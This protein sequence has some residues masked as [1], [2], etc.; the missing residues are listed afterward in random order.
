MTH[1]NIMFFTNKGRVFQL[2]AYRIPVA[3]R[4]SKGKPIVNLLPRLEDGEK[5]EDNLPIDS[6]DESLDLMFATRGG[7]VKRTP[8]RE[9]RNIRSNGIIAISLQDGDS[10]VDTRMVRQ[11]DEIVLATRNGQ[12]AR[13]EAS[14]VRSVGRPSIGVIGMRPDEGDEVV[15]MAVVRPEDKLLSITENGYGKIS[16][17]SDYRKTHRGGKGVITIK[18]TDRNGMVVSV[19]TINDDDQIILTTV[20]GNV[21][22]TRAE[23]IRTM[24]RSTQGVTIMG[25]TNGDKITAVARLVGAKEEMMVVHTE[26]KEGDDIIPVAGDPENEEQ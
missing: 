6:L 4:H 15:S 21:I 22:R 20:Q 17:V 12:A 19:S 26:A 8:L 16:L 18:T 7:I 13:F 1:N 14:E 5:V 3:G 2:K 23:E 24:G 11:D 25:L 9:Y 10:L